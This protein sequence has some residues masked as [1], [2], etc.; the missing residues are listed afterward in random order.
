M[1]PGLLA[2][3]VCYFITDDPIGV[4]EVLVRLAGARSSLRT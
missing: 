4:R 1:V 2:A 3:G